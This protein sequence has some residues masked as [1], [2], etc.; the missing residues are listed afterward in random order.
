M[1]CNKLAVANAVLQLGEAL[2]RATYTQP[3]VLEA[4]ALTLSAS[5]GEHFT[6]W[7]DGQNTGWP[8]GYRNRHLPAAEQQSIPISTI[9]ATAG[10]YVDICSEHIAL[11]IYASGAIEARDPWILNYQDPRVPQ[12]MEL[13]STALL[14]YAVQTAQAMMVSALQSAGAV[15][16]NVQQQSTATVLTFEV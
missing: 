3:H 11:R 5:F 14:A 4:L 16:T 9:A 10:Q 1:P 7:N 8:N 12:A 15:L 6:V 13:L 2:V